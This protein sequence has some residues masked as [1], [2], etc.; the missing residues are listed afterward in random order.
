[1]GYTVPHRRLSAFSSSYLAVDGANNYGDDYLGTQ[2]RGL[3][4]PFI[5]VRGGGREGGR[6]AGRRCCSASYHRPS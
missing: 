4:S 2:L 1:L 3:L 6:G 5:Q